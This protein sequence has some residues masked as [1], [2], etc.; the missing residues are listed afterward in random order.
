MPLAAQWPVPDP[1]PSLILPNS[2]HRGLL[3]R[4]VHVTVQRA[5]TSFASLIPVKTG[6]CAGHL[7][8]DA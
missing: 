7:Q 1:E 5:G 3:E 4:T 8:L 6:V 2:S